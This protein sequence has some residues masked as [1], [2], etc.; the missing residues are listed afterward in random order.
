M[1]GTRSVS[2]VL[3][4]IWVWGGCCNKRKQLLAVP[5]GQEGDV[6][7]EALTAL[8]A[9]TDDLIMNASIL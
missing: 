6:V 8:K 1:D 3:N 2:S 4:M 5:G 7:K 9:N